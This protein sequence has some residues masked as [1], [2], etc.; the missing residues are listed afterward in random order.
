MGA[1][2]TAIKEEGNHPSFD[3]AAG[4]RPQPSS[5]LVLLILKIVVTL[6][7]SRYAWRVPQSDHLSKIGACQRGGWPL[8]E[9]SPVARSP[10]DQRKR[11]ICMKGKW[12]FVPLWSSAILEAKANVSAALAVS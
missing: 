7:G 5:P 4:F 2:P 6:R 11:D 3:R 12:I 9:G 10:L 1:G 8:A